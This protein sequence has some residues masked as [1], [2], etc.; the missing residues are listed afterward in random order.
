[1]NVIGPAPRYRAWMLRCWEVEGDA[2]ARALPW[3]FSLEDP[4]TR[5][6]RGFASVESLVAF[7]LDELAH[8]RDLPEA[9]AS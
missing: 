6:R 4:H 9:D 2:P 5:E 8:R 1:V 3:Q 7:L